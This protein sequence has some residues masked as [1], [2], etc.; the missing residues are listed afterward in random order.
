MIAAPSGRARSSRSKQALSTGRG[1]SQ[2][3]PHAEIEHRAR[4]MLQDVG[5]VLGPI[6]SSRSP[7]PPFPGSRD[8]GLHEVN[9]LYVVDQ[10]WIEPLVGEI[11]GRTQ[12]AGYARGDLAESFFQQVPNFWRV[13]ARRADQGA[14][15]PG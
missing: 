15:C 9:A 14:I 8:G 12:R 5:E 11:R 2:A 6:T 4:H 1:S 10:R 13:A 7:G 3:R